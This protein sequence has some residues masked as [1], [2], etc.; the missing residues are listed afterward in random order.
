[1]TSMEVPVLPSGNTQW[2][3]P[4]M[5]M[6]RTLR[7]PETTPLVVSSSVTRVCPPAQAEA[8]APDAAAGQLDLKFT[9]YPRRKFRA[10]W[11]L[12]VC[13]SP[14]ESAS[15]TLMFTVRIGSEL[16]GMPASITPGLLGTT[17]KL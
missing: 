10:T 6:R 11:I 9:P 7:L 4:R 13:G 1:M 8:D 2:N 14:L 12:I 5:T 3:G 16:G 17:W 15:R